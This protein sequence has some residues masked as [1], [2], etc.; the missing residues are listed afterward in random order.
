MYSVYRKAENNKK[1]PNGG[2]PSENERKSELKEITKVAGTFFW[3]GCQQIFFLGI[4]DGSQ[5]HVVVT[6]FNKLDKV[7][8]PNGA[9]KVE[10]G[11]KEDERVG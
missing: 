3:W 1:W 2:G 6:F 9:L 10:R 7:L 11:L 4:K 8:T 5:G